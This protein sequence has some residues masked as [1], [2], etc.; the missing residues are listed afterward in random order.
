[1]ADLS[2]LLFGKEIFL[3]RLSPDDVTIDYVNWL[4]DPEVNQYLECRH[5]KHTLSST[6][7][8]VSELSSEDSSQLL[9]GVFTSQGE[10][11]IGTIN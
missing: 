7:D 5:N 3:R 8:Y 1:M 9:F 10:R 11:H 4:N 6:K 2:P